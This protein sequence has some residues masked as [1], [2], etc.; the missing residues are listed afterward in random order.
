MGVITD[1]QLQAKPSTKDIWMIE[2]GPRGAGRFVARITPAGERLFYFRYTGSSGDRVRLPLGSFPG[3]SVKQARAK[4][5]ELAALYRAGHRD[6]R[7]HLNRMLADEELAREQHRREQA[8]AELRAEAERNRR[9][10]F[11]QVFEQWRA[12]ELRPRI[13]A[14]GKRIGRKDGGHYVFE[15]FSRHVLPGVGN[16]PIEDI[17]KAD[18]LAL[19]D[20]QTTAGKSRTANV[21]LADLKQMLAFALDRDMIKLNPLASVRKGKIGGKDTERERVLSVEEIELLATRTLPARLSAAIWLTLATGARVGELMGAV[22]DDALPTDAHTKRAHVDSLR[23]LTDSMGCKFGIVDLKGRTWYLPTTKNQRSHTIHLSP[24]AVKQFESL[25]E[26]R[27]VMR[28]D[29]N[30]HLSPWVF[31]ATDNSKPVHVKS[32]GKQLADRQRGPEARLQGRT[33]QTQ[34]LA[35]PEGR[36]TAHDLRRTAATRMADLGISGDVIDECLNH[37][38][39]SRM[40]K[41][42][43]RSRRLE[44]QS[45]AFEALGSWLTSLKEGVQS[46]SVYRFAA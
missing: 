19:L 16:I 30:G 34:A 8:D 10:T 18:L 40:T 21:L 46:A 31:P 17:T 13:R 26:L 6:L 15:Q 1:K 22:W 12:T 20:A 43:V 14:D 36:W 27:E 3:M 35:L 9:K 44:H 7:E 25:L 33:A 4:F 45:K 38:S 42:Y 29:S 41:V 23:R 5:E 2:D 39:S 28:G 32:F 11:H 24:F 37:V